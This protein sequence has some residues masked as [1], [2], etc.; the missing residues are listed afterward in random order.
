MAGR[1]LQGFVEVIGVVSGL[2]GIVQFGMDNFAGEDDSVNSI[3][4]IA[5]GLDGGGLSNAG[6]DLPDVRL[7]NEFGDFLGMSADPGFV[8]D[9]TM[10]EIKVRHD[11]DLGQ[12]AT[13]TLFSANNN[14]ICIGMATITWPDGSNWGWTAQWADPCGASWFFSNLRFKGAPDDPIC[15][16]I[17]ANGDQPHTGFQIH[18][19]SWAPETPPEQRTP[20]DQVGTSLTEEQLCFSGPPF[21]LKTEPGPRGI[22]F[23]PPRR[24]FTKERRGRKKRHASITARFNE[25]TSG[26][27]ETTSGFNET[28]PGNNGTI[29]ANQTQTL[30]AKSSYRPWYRDQLVVDYNPAR[31]AK[32]LCNSDTSAGPDFAN[33]A[34]GLF[35]SMEDKTIYPFCD[36]VETTT[37]CF[38]TERQEVISGSAVLPRENRKRKYAKVLTWEGSGS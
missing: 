30:S 17:D 4:K 5:V 25:T 10:A 19:P 2:L 3:I 1:A 21:Q 34:E 35:C 22:V 12:Q 36:G 24:G 9:G 29:I 15:M 27:N 6:G 37:E 31:S 38:D 11:G 32:R 33:H 26:F 28:T 16:W 13:Y 23:A 20:E 7:F 8:A 14:A 18:W